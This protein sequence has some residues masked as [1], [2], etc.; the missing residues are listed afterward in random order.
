MSTT[1]SRKVFEFGTDNYLIGAFTDPPYA[2]ATV[3][4]VIAGMGIAEVRI[5]RTLANLG[6]VTLQFREREEI[7]DWKTAFNTRGVDN[8]RESL[9]LLHEKHGIE[10]FICV[11]NCGRG[12][13][14]FRIAVDDRRVTGLILTNPHISPALTIKESYAKRL[15]SFASWK[16]L[17]TGKANLRYHLPNVRLLVMSLLTRV[18]RIS[19]KALIDQS[20]HNQ[21]ATMPDR[22][23]E[24]AAH[25]VRRGAKVLMAFSENDEGL[26]YF[27]RLYGQS[28]ERLEAMAGLS[29]ELLPTTTHVPS[30]DNAA[31][32]ALVSMVDRWA[33]A[34]GFV[35]EPPAS[36][37]KPH[38]PGLSVRAL[39]PAAARFLERRSPRPSSRPSR[40][41]E[42][43]ADR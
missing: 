37:S 21:D 5:A 6:I 20:G 4:A 10:R 22:F 16:Q 3:G 9:E 42:R 29:I 25:L 28:F 39:Q 19:E 2:R 14:A 12:S 27:R 33:R 40:M 26:T 1:R 23:D 11:G 7:D 35:A 15:S 41:F 18:A 8:F 17:L 31:V 36:D 24:R 38:A 32:S 30:H 13:S 43:R 34:S